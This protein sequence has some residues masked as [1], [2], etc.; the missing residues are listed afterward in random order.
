MSTEFLCTRIRTR[1]TQLP[2]HGRGHSM[3][4]RNCC[5]KPSVHTCASAWPRNCIQESGAFHETASACQERVSCP[6]SRTKCLFGTPSDSKDA[7]GFGC[8]GCALEA[9]MEIRGKFGPLAVVGLW[10]SVESFPLSIAGSDHGSEVF[11]THT[12][13]K[14]EF[15]C[16]Q[17]TLRHKHAH[18][19]RN[20]PPV[21]GPCRP[22][23]R[24]VDFAP[25]LLRRHKR[26]H[27]PS[28]GL[29]VI[30]RKRI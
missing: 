9:Q 12:T 18:V 24:T 26:N 11:V 20:V 7:V 30:R 28:C 23:S 2:P 1:C 15:L 5:V 13:N 22:P 8:C 10:W 19:S 27:D 14:C 17:K 16:A 6:R 4:T 21:V 3:W 25:Q 29:S